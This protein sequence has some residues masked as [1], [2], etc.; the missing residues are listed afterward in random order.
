MIR[1]DIIRLA[2]EAGAGEPESLYGRT[3]YVVMTW[4]ELERFAN[5]VAAAERERID[6]NAI[7]TCHAECQNP[8][9]VRVR[10]AVAHEREACAKVCEEIAERNELEND[11]DWIP[12]NFE[13]ATA[14]RARGE[15][16]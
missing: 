4:F 10:E 15:S 7:H 2:Q 14:I 5:F 11:Y 8:F 16:K 13:C 6:L 9:C 12:G 3:D 1:D